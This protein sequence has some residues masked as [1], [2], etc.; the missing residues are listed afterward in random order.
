MKKVSYKKYG[1]S[2]VLKINDVD[3]PVPTKNEI[4][5]KVMA[6]SIN[7]IDWKNRKGRFR[8]VTGLIKPRVQQGFDISGIVE[9]VGSNISDIHRGSRIIGQLNNF[10]GGAFAE[11]AILKKGQYIEAP[12]K[13]PFLN[14]AGLP[15]A[16]TTAW[17]ALLKNANLKENS[18][19]LINGGSS[20]VGHYAIQI[21]KAYGAKVTAVCS[22]KNLEFCYSLGADYCIDYTKSDFT[23]QKI[24]YD[25]IF[26]VVNNKSLKNVRNVLQR[27]GIYIGT[28]PTLQ[29]LTSILF[30]MFS[31]KKAQFV[32]V[33]PDIKALKDILN[34]VL[35][36]KLDTI[37]DKTFPIDKIVEAHDY[38][39]QSR[40]VGKVIIS[41][42]DSDS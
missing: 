17:Q 11:Y 27:K 12:S 25:I 22:T 1:N 15:M 39:E 37:I 23:K 29:L 5:V 20:G 36:K 6:S 40:T 14:L 35:K 8:L 9:K 26:D 42:K 32:A 18:M 19:V 28:T 7:A 2:Q 4:L 30:S 41:M 16:A 33:Q 3:I 24:K 13:I 31:G 34:L 10:K 38:S 21:A